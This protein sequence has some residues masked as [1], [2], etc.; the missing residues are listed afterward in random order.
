[1][2]VKDQ[3]NLLPQLN[4]Q[5]IMVSIFFIMKATIFDAHGSIEQ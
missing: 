5:K 4:M 3:T 1:M 2:C